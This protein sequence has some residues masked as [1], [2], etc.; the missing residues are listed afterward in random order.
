MRSHDRHAHSLPPCTAPRRRLV[1]VRLAAPMPP[2]RLAS[3]ARM[4]RQR[5]ENPT[6]PALFDSPQVRL[7]PPHDRAAPYN[8]HSQA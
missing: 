2:I 1:F 5:N 6:I 3:T 7:V 8:P 4:L